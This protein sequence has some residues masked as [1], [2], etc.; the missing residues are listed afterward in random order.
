MTF[1]VLVPVIITTRPTSSPVCLGDSMMMTRAALLF[2]A[3]LFVAPTTGLVL[4]P[5]HALSS[6]HNGARCASIV[7]GDKKPGAGPKKKAGADEKGPKGPPKKEP[8]APPPKGK[9]EPAAAPKK[10]GAK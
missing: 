5:V 2:L 4:S 1:A 3:A 10:K 7:A 8:E 9:A 6:V